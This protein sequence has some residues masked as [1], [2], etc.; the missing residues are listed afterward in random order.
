MAKRI[1]VFISGGG[2][3]LQAL[4]DASQKGEIKGEIAL[5][6]SDRKGA[7]GL[8]RARSHGITNLYINQRQFNSP[9]DYSKYL[10]DTMR[11]H[12]IDLI[13]LAGCL[14]IL[15]RELV[16]LYKN[17]IVNI[18]PSLIPSFCGQGFYGERVHRAVLDYGV[19]I[20]GATVH[21]LD[22]GTD[23]GPIILQKPVYIGDLNSAEEIQERVLSTEHQILREAVSY[24]CDERIVVEGR[25]VKIKGVDI[26]E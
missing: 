1:A 9:E 11:E 25:R 10:V 2:S 12:A 20:T 26:C 23:T 6:I 15:P 16:E 22:E 8:E 7:Y 19:K 14:T 18:H 21:F 17:A 24:I 13:V 3:N 4:I 5:V